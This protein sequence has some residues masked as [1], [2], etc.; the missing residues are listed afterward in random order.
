[1]KS[2]VLAINAIKVERLR[3]I[4]RI[5]HYQACLDALTGPAKEETLRCIE[6]LKKNARELDAITEWIEDCYEG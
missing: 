1:M 6:E 5:G 3:I 2:S 4:D